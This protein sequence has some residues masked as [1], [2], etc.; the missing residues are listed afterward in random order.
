MNHKTSA[1]QPVRNFRNVLSS[2]EIYNLINAI[3]IHLID[4]GSDRVHNAAIHDGR[5]IHEVLAGF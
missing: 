4:D 1:K 3:D 5:S 2:V